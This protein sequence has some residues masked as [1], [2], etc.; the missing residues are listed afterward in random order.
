MFLQLAYVFCVKRVACTHSWSVDDC[1]YF[2]F[3]MEEVCN[4]KFAISKLRFVIVCLAVSLATQLFRLC[5]V[6]GISPS[7]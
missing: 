1:C 7:G 6:A 5:S 4:S 2:K 3:A